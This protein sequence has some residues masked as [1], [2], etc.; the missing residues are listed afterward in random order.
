[1]SYSLLNLINKQGYFGNK[2]INFKI[3]FDFGTDSKPSGGIKPSYLPAD[4]AVPAIEISWG[5]TW[6]KAKSL[7]L[8]ASNQ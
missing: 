3:Y 5:K 4:K 8:H 6:M 2:F 1:L 7:R